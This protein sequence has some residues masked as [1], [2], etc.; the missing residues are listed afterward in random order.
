M[1]FLKRFLFTFI[2]LLAATSG[3]AGEA[4]LEGAQVAA[5]EEFAHL[6]DIFMEMRSKYPVAAVCK[7]LERQTPRG[8]LACM[9]AMTHQLDARPKSISKDFWDK[10]L[11]GLEEYAGFL[12]RVYVVDE[13]VPVVHVKLS[14]KPPANSENFYAWWKRID[15]D[16]YIHFG[17]IYFDYHLIGIRAA[18]LVAWELID[19]E[20]LYK[21]DSLNTSLR[22]LEHA[23]SKFNGIPKFHG[24]YERITKKAREFVTSMKKRI[25]QR[26]WESG[27][28]LFQSGTFLPRVYQDL[29]LIKPDQKP[30]PIESFCDSFLSQYGICLHERYGH[31]YHE[32]L[33]DQT[34]DS[35]D[36]LECDLERS[37]M[38]LD[39]RIM[40]MGYEGSAFDSY[41]SN[42]NDLVGDSLCDETAFKGSG[43]WSKPPANYFGFLTA[44]ALRDVNTLS[45]TGL[46]EHIHDDRVELF[47]RVFE[48]LQR[49]SFT[50]LFAHVRSHEN[51]ARSF[52]QA[53]DV[54]GVLNG[55]V[56]FFEF[57]YDKNLM[58]ADG[59]NVATQDIL[60]NRK[61][62]QHLIK[63]PVKTLKFYTG[64][65]ITYPILPTK[66]RNSFATAHAQDFVKK[67]VTY[68]TPRGGDTT[69]YVFNSFVDGV[70]KST[71]LGNI[72]NWIKHGA[73]MGN[74]EVTDNTSSQLADI[75]EFSK[76]VYIADL[77]AQISHFT[78]K[79]DGYVFVDVTSVKGEEDLATDVI[80]YF[81]E[82]Q[83]QIV[84][85]YCNRIK[86]V[87]QVVATD[88]WHADELNQPT[89]PFDA[90]VKNLQL[91]KLTA[92]NPW[93]PCEFEGKFFLV[94][95]QNYGEVRRFMPLSEAQSSGL[96]NVR[97]DQMFFF[98]GI[99]L[100]L[101]YQT[102]LD[103]LTSRCLEK[104]VKRVVFVDFLSMYMR[105]SRENIRVNYLMQQMALLFSEFDQKDTVYRDLTGNAELLYYLENESWYQRAQKNLEREALVR[106]GFN[107]L[108]EEWKTKTLNKV[109]LKETSERVSTLLAA[110]EPEL[111]ETI[112]GAAAQKLQSAADHLRK[113]TGLSKEFVNI[114]CMSW[115]DILSYARLLE[116][117]MVKSIADKNV[118]DL[119]SSFGGDVLEP[120]E[121]ACLG[122]CDRL[123][124]TSG[125][126]LVRVRCVIDPEDRSS[127]TLGPIFRILRVIWYNTIFQFID[128]RGGADG[129][130]QPQN[131]MAMLP[132]TVRKGTNGLIYLVQPNIDAE[133]DEL[134]E[135]ALTRDELEIIKPF[136]NLE[137]TQWAC[138]NKKYMA[139]DIELKPETNTTLREYAFGC[140]SKGALGV[141]EPKISQYLT[142]R[143]VEEHVNKVGLDDVLPLTDAS[144]R[145]ER[146]SEDLGDYYWSKFDRLLGAGNRVHAAYKQK[147]EPDSKD[148]GVRDSLRNLDPEEYPGV[149]LFLML[150]TRL[151]QAVHDPDSTL[152]VRKNNKKDAVG[153]L[154]FLE[155]VVLPQYFGVVSS[156][157]LA[158][159]E[160]LQKA[161]FRR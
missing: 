97:A 112:A 159:N 78:Y 26:K 24:Y 14:K 22:A 9:D 100:P 134:P 31:E 50:Q 122:E 99:T 141:K 84:A 66:Q 121:E 29:G 107:S 109:S 118:V 7:F 38:K 90:F 155:T 17:G 15:V 69:V 153:A 67:F 62:I 131:L 136:V 125:G 88:G 63:S 124:S 114:Q 42:F 56:N 132:W 11:R 138:V 80:D 33:L 68:L 83:E 160:K 6:I 126:K 60:F 139:M 19:P 103:D 154:K 2:F 65:D 43:G 143:I 41:F 123:V 54:N 142:S 23:V 28:V 5:E 37:G 148:L 133:A 16:S 73:D 127:I 145:M 135:G 77:P 35:Y 59:Q 53:D 93:V 119:W 150:A 61:H 111:R 82:N 110:L 96:K 151:E 105:S 52:V 87:S 18:V 3:A 51:A 13:D 156:R 89:N 149:E 120:I 32:Y 72:K 157:N 39:G 144:E 47:P 27:P 91:L 106:W 21:D 58:L 12:E 116:D 115:D 98:D 108:L 64:A 76:D 45:K 92:T 75:F 85:N 44:F 30:A 130:L 137:T 79:P 46:F 1:T 94:N 10:M 57:L 81:M 129:K 71:M 74:Y 34:A 95:A 4:N 36:K 25:S 8:I 104:G 101:S 152:V 113:T 70:G 86:R 146:L 128:A 48:L 161:L 117:I 140:E 55:F 158:N 49:D 20:S 147:K 40:V 102:F